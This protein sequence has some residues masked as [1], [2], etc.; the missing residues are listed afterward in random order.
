MFTLCAFSKTTVQTQE[1]LQNPVSGFKTDLSLNQVK[2]VDLPGPQSDKSTKRL[3]I[4]NLLNTPL[5][6]LCRGGTKNNLIHIKTLFE[7]NCTWLESD[8]P[9]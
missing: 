4:K 5:K 3:R 7:V 1:L 2:V 6:N 9:T 8:V